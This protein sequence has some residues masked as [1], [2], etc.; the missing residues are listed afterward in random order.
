M[1][2]RI[3][4]AATYC[5]ANDMISIQVVEKEQLVK[6]LDQRS[7]S[8]GGNIFQ[9]QFYYVTLQACEELL[10]LLLLL[11]APPGNRFTL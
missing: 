6:K 2:D 1:V 10:Q 7:T 3:T 11:L 4:D 9:F 8:Q 5:F